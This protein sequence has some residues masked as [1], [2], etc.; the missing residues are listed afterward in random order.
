M[1]ALLSLNIT[2][3]LSHLLAVPVNLW[4]PFYVSEKSLI[5]TVLCMS[6][7]KSFPWKA[8]ITCQLPRQQSTTM[9]RLLLIFF[10]P[11]LWYFPLMLFVRDVC[12]YA[13]LCW[14]VEQKRRA[15]EIPEKRLE[16]LGHCLLWMGRLNS[17]QMT[18]ALWCR[19]LTR[20]VVLWRAKHVRQTQFTCI[21]AISWSIS[22]K[23]KFWCGRKMTL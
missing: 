9:D 6:V 4:L 21:N 13:F 15:N 10:R 17:G 18:F 23:S 14:L 20:R 19:F 12:F 8:G 5:Y 7:G 11:S 3:M 16:K 1:V 22:Q 2:V